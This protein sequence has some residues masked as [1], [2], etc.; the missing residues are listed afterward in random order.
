[1]NRKAEHIDDRNYIA[2]ANDLIR[3]LR[4]NDLYKLFE[5]VINEQKRA[6]SEERHKELKAVYEVIKHQPKLD[7]GRLMRIERGYGQM[8]QNARAKDGNTIKYGKKA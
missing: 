4:I 6:A 5:I 1:M 7:S 8:A 2:Q 3:G